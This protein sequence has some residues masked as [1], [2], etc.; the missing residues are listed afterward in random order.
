[1]SRMHRSSAAGGVALERVDEGARG[2]GAGNAHG[3]Q[4]AARVQTVAGGCRSLFARSHRPVAVRLF[5]TFPRCLPH[6]PALAAPAAPAVPYRA[7]PA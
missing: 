1:M 3:A 6:L 2:G 4:A 5:H 7:C